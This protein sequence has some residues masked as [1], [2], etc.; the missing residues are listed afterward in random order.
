MKKN[1]I[2]VEIRKN[3]WLKTSKNNSE[4]KVEN[5]RESVEILKKK[6]LDWSRG[7][8]EDSNMLIKVSSIEGPNKGKSKSLIFERVT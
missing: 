1:K 4:Q 3:G 8:S 2:L 7:E 6:S 5:L